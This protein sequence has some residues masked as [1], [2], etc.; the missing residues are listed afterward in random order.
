MGCTSGASGGGAGKFGGG[1]IG[2]NTGTTVRNSHPLADEIDRG[3]GGF[4]NEIMNT[5]DAF[6][7]EYGEAVKRINLHAATFFVSFAPTALSDQRERVITLT[8]NGDYIYSRKIPN[9]DD[10]KIDTSSAEYKRAL[11]DFNVKAQFNADGSVSVAS[12]GLFSQ[13]QKF[14]NTGD[15]QK[16]TYK[17]ID[18]NISYWKSEENRVKSGKLTQLEAENIKST[19]KG[20]SKSMAI[21]EINNGFKEQIAQAKTYT[22]AGDDMKRRLSVAINK[23]KK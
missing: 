7:A 3:G 17:R 14:K 12:G 21:K 16:E 22:A 20:K 19:V 1:M 5:R 11:R 2:K 8:E 6:E 18:N 10:V 4:A 23:A 9:F 13:K 15:F